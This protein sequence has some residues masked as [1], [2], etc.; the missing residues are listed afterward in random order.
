MAKTSRLC[1]VLHFFWYFYILYE[2]EQDAESLLELPETFL[3]P[4][5]LLSLLWLGVNWLEGLHGILNKDCS[6]H[7]CT[8]LVIAQIK[9]TTDK[10][11]TLSPFKLGICFRREH[12]TC[13]KPVHLE[14]CEC[15]IKITVKHLPWLKKAPYIFRIPSCVRDKV[16]LPRVLCILDS[17]DRNKENITPMSGIINP[18]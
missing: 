13:P 14:M 4:I 18:K 2:N 8:H 9:Q 15:E 17:T 6:I 10:L 3:L 12:E 7:N 5:K 11:L 16:L 1:V